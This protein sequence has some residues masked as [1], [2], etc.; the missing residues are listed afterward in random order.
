MAKAATATRNGVRTVSSRARLASSQGASRSH[1][2]RSVPAAVE[3]L[4]HLP[5]RSRPR[6]SQVRSTDQPLVGGSNDEIRP[7]I[8][9]L[10]DTVHGSRWRFRFPSG[11]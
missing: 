7:L 9:L 3:S 4:P 2:A 5:A 8:L 6:Q 1:A 10:P 11:K